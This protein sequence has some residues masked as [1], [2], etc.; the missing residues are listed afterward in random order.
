M[1]LDLQTKI[2]TELKSI[3]Q[4]AIESGEIDTTILRMVVLS[5]DSLFEKLSVCIC[6]VWDS[7]FHTDNT[8]VIGEI[9]ISEW[10]NLADAALELQRE[11]PDT[12]IELA[13]AYD[14]KY[15]VT[16]PAFN[17]DHLEILE[18]AY[19]SYLICLREELFFQ[20]EIA[21]RAVA[22]SFEK[23]DFA[24]VVGFATHKIPY[25][26]YSDIIIQ[27]FAHPHGAGP[28]YNVRLTLPEYNYSQHYLGFHEN[29]FTLFCAE[30]TIYNRNETES[31]VYNFDFSEI[32]FFTIEENEIQFRLE[33]EFQNWK[34]TSNRVRAER[35]DKS[36]Q[37]FLAAFNEQLNKCP[38]KY[39]NPKNIPN[40][41]T[42]NENF[43]H[44]FNTVLKYNIPVKLAQRK[45][46]FDYGEEAYRNYLG[47]L[48]KTNIQYEPAQIFLATQLFYA[49]RFEESL[50][51]FG[52]RIKLF[53][54]DKILCLSSLF[55]LCNKDAYNAYK[56]IIE[57]A[58]EQI[59]IDLLDA[60]WLLREPLELEVL[61]NLKDKLLPLFTEYK[62]KPALRLISLVLTKLYAVLEDSEK[63]LLYLQSVPTHQTFEKVI[64][65][66]ELKQD[67][68]LMQAY[69]EQVQRSNAR[70]AF[71]NYAEMHALN[72]SEKKKVLREK[73]TYEN[74]FY[75]TQ[76]IRIDEFKWA[77]PLGADAF[78]AVRKAK[79]YEFILAKI[80]SENSIEILQLIT[81]PDTC[82]AQSCAYAEGF[83]YIVDNEA[84][85]K[86]FK[87][88]EHS[89]EESDIV[90]RNKKT[91]ANY[92]NLTV[93]DGYL[94]VS[95]ND[96]L[97]IYELNNPD[98]GLISDSLYINSGY[99]LFV[100][101]NLL[102]VGA[103]AG[104]VILADISDKANPLCLSTILEDS[105]QGHIAIVGDYLVSRSVYNIQNPSDPQWISFVGD[106]L[107][108]TYYFAP[109]PEVP[110]ISTGGEFLFTTILVENG[111]PVYTNWWESLNADNLIYES[112]GENLATAYLGNTLVTFA[113][114]EIILWEK[115]LSPVKQKVDI[116]DEVEAMVHE[117]FI[118]LLEEHPDFRVGKVILK[119]EPMYNTIEIAFHAAST[120][121]ILASTAHVHQQPIISSYFHCEEFCQE[122]LMKE[123]DPQR[124]QFEYDGESILFKLADDP[125]FEKI[126]ARHVLVSADKESMYI[127]FLNK[128]WKP[129]RS[130]KSSF[131]QTELVEKTEEID[132]KDEM[133]LNEILEWL[134]K[135]VI[136]NDF[137]DSGNPFLSNRFEIDLKELGIE[138][139]TAEEEEENNIEQILPETILYDCWFGKPYFHGPF[140]MPVIEE[141]G[142]EVE[143]YNEEGDFIGE[144]D[145]YYNPETDDYEV[146]SSEENTFDFSYS[147][148]TDMRLIA[149]EKLC[150]L[151]DRNLV[152]NIIFNGIKFG[153]MHY[154]LKDLP[155]YY[156]PDQL[157]IS[158]FVGNMY[159]LWDEFGQDSDIRI[160]LMNNIDY[161]QS[162]EL[163]AKI[164]YLCGHLSHPALLE[165]LQLQLENG[166]NFYTYKGLH[167]G[168]DLSKLPAE[169]LK[170]I[171]KNLL[172]RLN[173]FETTTDAYLRI[174]AEEQIVYLYD[175][176]SKLG[177]ESIF[178]LVQKKMAS[179]VKE[180]E[181]YGRCDDVFDEDY[182]DSVDEIA[183]I[184]SI[185]RTQKVKRVL[186]SFAKNDSAV[187]PIE[188]APELYE[189]S[190]RN[191][192]DKLLEMG[193]QKFG[194]D[195]KSE[196]IARLSATIAGDASFENDRLLATEIVQ[197]TFHY[198]QKRP[199]LASMTEPLILSIFQHRE[200]FSQI[201]DIATLKDK[202][203]YALLQAAWNDLKNQDWDL[204]EQKADAVL[205]LDSTMGQVYFLKA[206]LL[207]LREGIPAYLAQQETFVEKASHDAVALARLYN[208][209]GCA[210]DVEKRYEEALPYFKKAALTHPQEPMYVA[211]VAEIYYKLQMPKE[212]L[213]HAKAA[214]ASGNK[215][216][217]V[218]E[219]IKNSGVFSDT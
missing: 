56:P 139:A 123:F 1:Q 100:Q 37:E 193:E 194:S 201:P 62:N 74:C 149:F 86:T 203:K 152:R 59:T 144:R 60:L 5:P 8:S 160:F 17:F 218:E 99:Y 96:Y 30:G 199:Q 177:H 118:F 49:E 64:F 92:E 171:E 107:A 130:D 12:Y 215:G 173:A 72:V 209:T 28:Y 33:D 73:S 137:S 26:L 104:L 90:Y 120:L 71:D 191:T 21:I 109:K 78:I 57:S 15:A 174:V 29:G 79:V 119:F 24:H 142:E 117:T 131:D 192:I 169:A 156:E 208:L 31:E 91:K 75:V 67:T 153:Y 188:E 22:T 19:Q 164:A 202:S 146:N 93:A 178:D 138:K 211:N 161:F 145:E 217:I 113:K 102:V 206:R 213:K 122:M 18:K 181:K 52:S 195:F 205:L 39:F 14:T 197:F 80:T 108:P 150:A 61:N 176:L 158:Q 183:F 46:I 147:H 84:G 167:N 135:K 13:K 204:A 190:W 189:E 45:A 94:Y 68:Y 70:V 216:G 47:L 185:Y 11:I 166:I 88:S 180:Y 103:G 136:D 128:E 200:K 114:Y 6:N 77:C 51:L 81:L 42:E 87:V 168:I 125:K 4:K 44:W 134:N 121:A 54:S 50:E 140:H 115:G 127:H 110:V 105:T 82:N 141:E 212:A 175:M 66:H 85:I 38:E 36:E 151:P 214:Q 210:L 53:D 219:I 25:D 187:W 20:I 76:K 143:N 7:Y 106:K 34:L 155:A 172:D 10:M 98:S 27:A 186:R 116:H 55:L 132:A 2:E 9:N 89:I 3:L 159:G 97:E 170:P 163:R 198:I 63:A 23:E 35:G 196:L 157:L 48:P 65:K 126:A 148:A 129:F 133:N 165:Y 182:D 43:L 40:P 41:I 58:E 179:A 154:S 111:K 207:W 69:E 124:M 83:F 95:N 32:S 112:A 162:Y 184:I 101:N 16:A